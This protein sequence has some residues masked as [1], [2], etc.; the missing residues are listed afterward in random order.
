M[1]P[2]SACSKSA[3][4]LL[5]PSDTSIL[6]SWDAEEWE[7]LFPSVV[8]GASAQVPSLPLSAGADADDML[9]F[10]ASEA[11]VAFDQIDAGGASLEVTALERRVAKLAEE[12]FEILETVTALSDRAIKVGWITE[13]EK[14]RNFIALKDQMAQTHDLDLRR[15]H[16]ANE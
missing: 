16:E 6:A 11:T 15:R 1:K 2:P 5:Q 10:P 14:R 8:V 4:A 13:T 9:P 7:P 3:A 12:N